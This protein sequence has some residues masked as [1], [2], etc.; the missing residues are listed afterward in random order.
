MNFT[1]LGSTNSHEGYCLIKTVEKKLTA[2]GVPYLDM[3][4]ADN[5]GEINAKLWDYK[6]SPSNQFNALDFVKVRG[7]YVP[8]NDT[9]QFRVERIRNVIPEDNVAIEDYVPSA[10]LTGQVMLA[11]IEKTVAAFK[12]NELKILVGAVIERYREKLLYWPA[13]KNL[14]HAVRSGLLMH[15]LSILRL[16][17]G[18]CSVYRF[19]NYDLLCAG[20]ILH[21]IAKIDEM[22]AS[23]TGIAAEYTVKGN[24]LG[25]LVMGAISIDR[26]GRELGISD[27]TLTL[28]EHMLISHHGTPE[29]GAAKM[30][31]FIEAELLSQLDLMDAR[32]YEMHAAVEAVEEGAFTPRQWA[33]ENRNLYNHGKAYDGGVELMN[34]EENQ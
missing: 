30:P 31:M 16:A 25:H 34:E 28:I 14:H 6:E 27:E 23:A 29:F 10:C 13:A 7:T 21:D 33:L 17:K 24:L 26:I 18:V 20:A 15:T 22:Q 9:V 2:K 4:L 3:T 19:V 32:L 8:F 11:E 12:D 5:S 1:P